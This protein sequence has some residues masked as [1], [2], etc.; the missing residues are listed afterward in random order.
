MP[1]LR[2][3]AVTLIAVAMGLLGAGNGVVFQLIPQRFHRQIGVVTGVVGAAGGL[4]GF[5]LPSVLG[6]TKEASGSFSPG[7]VAFATAALIAAGAVRFAARGWS[8]EATALS[9]AH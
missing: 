6:L 2:A 9:P 5:L 7:L 4:G 8:A 3:S 1:E